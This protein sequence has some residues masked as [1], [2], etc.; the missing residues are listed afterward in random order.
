MK[1]F[2]FNK[3]KPKNLEDLKAGVQV[4]WKRLTQEVC[5]RYVS[6]LQ[7]VLPAVLAKNGGPSG[8]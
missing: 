7:K 8:H 6:H 5:S 3:H 1:T 2:L 4:Y